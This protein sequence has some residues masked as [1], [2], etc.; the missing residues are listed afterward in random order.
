MPGR[1]GRRCWKN[2]A[3]APG[4]LAPPNSSACN[5]YRGPAPSVADSLEA[6]G[7]PKPKIGEGPRLAFGGTTSSHWQRQVKSST[8]HLAL[9]RPTRQNR[10]TRTSGATRND[11]KTGFVFVSLRGLA[12]GAEDDPKRG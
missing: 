2:W 6:R 9:G 1:A 3:N 10:S 7:A 4:P 8:S 12:Q 11:M 5:D